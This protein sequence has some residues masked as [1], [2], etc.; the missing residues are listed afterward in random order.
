MSNGLYNL[1]DNVILLGYVETDKG[2]NYLI[3]YLGNFIKY[4][5]KL[6]TTHG[7][8]HSPIT[9]SKERNDYP[10]VIQTAD[11]SFLRLY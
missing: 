8:Q 10:D 1:S 4:L 9:F 7:I 2:N 11:V 6:G 5:M 3:E